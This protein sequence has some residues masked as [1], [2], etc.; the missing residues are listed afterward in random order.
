MFFQALLNALIPGGNKKVTHIQT[1][2]QLSA[3]DLFKY[4]RCV[5]FLLP[6]GIKGLLHFVPTLPHIPI[7]LPVF[8][9]FWEELK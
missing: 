6:L 9:I 8:C 7:L 4:V 5:T 1:D 3:T 2:L